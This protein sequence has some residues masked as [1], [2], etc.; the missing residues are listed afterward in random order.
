M[1]HQLPISKTIQI[2][3]PRHAG[4]CRRCKDESV[5]NILL[6]TSTYEYAS[7]GRPAVTY[8]YQLCA[9]T[10]CNLEDLPKAMDDRDGLRQRQRQTEKERQTDRQRDS[11][12]STRSVRLDDDDNDDVI[13][14]RSFVLYRKSC[15]WG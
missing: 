10:G 14:H 6:W 2:W 9:N 8:L 1:G 13:A 3:W 4:Q 7:V 12:K 11:G 15:R 5:N